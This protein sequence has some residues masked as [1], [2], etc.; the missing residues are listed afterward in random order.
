MSHSLQIFLHK[1]GNGINEFNNFPILWFSSK[2]AAHEF[3]TK[4]TPLKN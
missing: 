2:K 4:L 1:T 3:V